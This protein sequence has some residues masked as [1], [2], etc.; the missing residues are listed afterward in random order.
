MRTMRC[1]GSRATAALRCRADALRQR[2]KAADRGDALR[3]MRARNR[4]VVGAAARRSRRS[5]ATTVLAQRSEPV[6]AERRRTRMRRRRARS[7]PA[8]RSRSPSRCARAADRRASW[9]DAPT[10]SSLRQRPRVEFA[11]NCAARRCT[12]TPSRRASAMSPLTSTSRAGAATRV[13]PRSRPAGASARAGN[14]GARSCTRRMPA[15]SAASSA[16]EPRCIVAVRRRRDQVAIRLQQRGDDRASR[17]AASRSALSLCG[18]DPG[19]RLPFAAAR[20]CRASWRRGA[21]P[22]AGACA[23]SAAAPR[24]AAR[25]S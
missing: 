14:R 1:A 10:R 22:G 13:A 7:G 11:R 21:R 24:S 3:A 8:R 2:P 25:R 15:A 20:A 23:D 12:P 6:P 17:P 19:Q 4:D 5:A 18:G 16:V 9:Q